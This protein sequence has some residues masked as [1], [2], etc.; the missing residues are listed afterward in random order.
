MFVDFI[1]TSRYQS[2]WLKLK[3]FTLKI[4]G[5]SVPCGSTILHK[6]N[7]QITIQPSLKCNI[8]NVWCD[9][10]IRVLTKKILPVQK[11]SPIFDDCRLYCDFD[12]ACFSEL[13]YE[14]FYWFASPL[15][16]LCTVK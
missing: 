16:F 13:R 15:S 10:N 11:V 4:H 7:E 8:E 2:P 9:W 1:C 6:K 12:S 14:E 3:L 5:A